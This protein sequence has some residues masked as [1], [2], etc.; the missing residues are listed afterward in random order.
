M[1]GV[2]N[3]VSVG[4][5]GSSGGNSNS[6][7]QEINGQTGSVITLV[8]TSGII[9][10]PVAPNQINIGYDAS[11][12]VGVNGITVEQIGGNFVVNGSSLSGISPTKFAQ[13]FTDITSGIFT[14]NFN[15][16]DVLVQI[17][18][19]N[20]HVILPDGIIVENGDQV[21]VLFNRPQSGRVVII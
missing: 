15:T 5:F 9:V 11:G 2:G 4:G 8:G 20:R 6:G 7:I 21:S 18:D 14:H 1:V 3:I 19:S 17:Y 12:V 16:I 13:S 10:T